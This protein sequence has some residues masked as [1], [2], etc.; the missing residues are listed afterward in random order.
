MS[1]EI[2]LGRCAVEVQSCRALKGTL[3]LQEQIAYLHM[4][5]EKM[6]KRKEGDKCKSLKV[7]HGFETAIPHVLWL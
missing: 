1:G 4:R 7:L 3:L 2:D 6:F 5:A